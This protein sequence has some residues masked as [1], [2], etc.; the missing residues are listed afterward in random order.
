MVKYCSVFYGKERDKK[1]LSY[2]HPQSP[3]DSE[4]LKAQA[5]NGHSV[6]TTWFYS[7]KRPVG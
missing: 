6:S 5:I 1:Q 7:T 4:H 2:H 3:Q